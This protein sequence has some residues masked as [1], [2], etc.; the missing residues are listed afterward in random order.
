MISFILVL[1]TISCSQSPA[2]PQGS[3]GGDGGLV[4]GLS[5]KTWEGGL[6]VN[7]EGFESTEQLRADRQVFDT[8]NLNL[9]KISLDFDD[10]YVEGGLTRSMRYDFESQG[11]NSV[12]IGRGILLPTM[13]RELWGEVVIK[14]SRNFTPCNPNRTRCDHKT[15]FYRVHPAE[16]N[17]RWSLHVGGGAGEGGPDV[18]V[19]IFT[20]RG[21]VEGHPDWVKWGLPRALREVDISN[22]PS[23]VPANQ[24]YDEEWH[25]VR[26]YVRHSTDEES[27]DAQMKL[28]IDGELLY[29]TAELQA[30]YGLPRFGTDEQL[31]IREILVGRNKD[32]GLDNGTESMWVARIRAWK[33]NPGW[34]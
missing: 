23:M 30:K 3:V 2:A 9:E 15:L 21:P 22:R 18:N 19:T 27:Y 17:G 24:Y 8:G 31:M 7:L 12:H 10:P 4:P 1:A 11:V 34:D 32:A 16:D 14:W 25:V 28:W 13:V 33:D 5:D 26:M 6:D 20:P 29:D